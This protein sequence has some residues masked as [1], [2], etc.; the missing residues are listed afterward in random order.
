M[1]DDRFNADMLKLARDAREFT[2]ADLAKAAGVTQALV[3]KIENGLIGQ[4]SEDVV[5]KLAVAVKF[6]PTFF[7]Q[8]EKIVGFPHFHYRKRAKLGTKAT[9]HIG[10]IINIRRQHVAKLLR[11]CEMAPPK[12]IPQ[13]DLDESGLTPEK[14]AERLRAYWMLPR[15]PVANVVELVE[16]AGGIVVLCRFGTALLDGLS[17]RAEGLPPLF[18]MN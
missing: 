14:V 9:A 7:Y 18:F 13:I 1:S 8:T 16:A 2:Q 5:E 12:P 17:F 6:P 11:S 15:G 10:A 3:S 4:P